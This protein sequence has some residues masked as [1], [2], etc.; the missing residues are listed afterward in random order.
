MWELMPL[1]RSYIEL[2][3]KYVGFPFYGSSNYLFGARRFEL[4]FF[5]FFE[6]FFFFA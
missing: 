2:M 6:K 4:F 3:V 1:K 5:S